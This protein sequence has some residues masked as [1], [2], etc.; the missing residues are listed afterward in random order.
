MSTMDPAR[1]HRVE[2]ALE[3]AL[4]EPLDTRERVIEARCGKDPELIA[5][6]RSLLEAH[7][8][9]GDF[10]ESSA[11]TFASEHLLELSG[12]GDL[13]GT[14]VGRYRLLE[15]IGRGGMGT[16]WLAERADGQFEQRVA[17]KL[18]RRGMDSSDIVSRF[19]RERQILA[20]LEHPNI[21]RLLDGGVSEDGRPYFVME[22]VAGVPITRACTARGLPVGERLRR[23]VEVC[24]AVQYAH[25][26]LIIHGDIK[27]GN[28][29]LDE[30]GA[31]KL[32]D[33]G[34]ARLMAPEP[35]EQ[36]SEGSPGRG[37]MTPEY[38]SPEQQ[39]GRP[40]TTA[41]DV[42]QLG[43]LLYEL[44]TAQRLPRSPTGGIPGREVRG[45]LRAI[46]AK[47]VR[48]DPEQRYPSVEAL[49]DD[50]DRH[51]AARRNRVALFAAGLVAALAIGLT[52]AYLVRIRTERDR[53]QREAAKASEHSD[54]LSRIFRGWSPDAADRSSVSAA[55]LLD[56]AARRAR[57]ELAAQPELLGATL[58]MLG[59][60]ES[61]I[62]RIAVADTLLLEA[63][64]IQ[65]REGAPARDRA[66]T[67][68]RQGWVQLESGRLAEAEGTLQQAL[69]LTRDGSVPPEDVAQIRRNLG[70][71]L[72]QLQRLPDAESV[73]REALAT[74]PEDRTP[75]RTEL[76]AFLGYVL[77][78]QGRYD[79]AEQLI[80]PALI[81]QR[82]L[83]G[84][85]HVSTLTTMR[86]LAS[87]LRGPASLA[88]A[89]ALDREA[90][91]VSR[92]LFG[93]DHR[94][95]AAT[96]YSL[97][98]LLERKGNFLAAD[99]FGTSALG[100]KLRLYGERSDEAA[101]ILRTL[102]GI[103]LVLKDTV[104]AERLLLRSLA[105]F[106]AAFPR[107]HP[108]EGDVLNRLAYLLIR[109]RAG[110]ADSIYRRAIGFEQAR[111]PANPFF[112]T[113]GYEYLAWA[114]HQ[115]GDRELAERLYRRALDLYR[116]EL[117]EEHPYRVQADEGL[118]ELLRDR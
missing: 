108:D 97:A 56:D 111:A 105:S 37:P 44:V 86:F 34:V 9:A 76:A 7:R 72:W 8:A 106:Q 63:L 60:F 69:A 73:L 48:P 117:P 79:E 31:V 71:A 36:S 2:A 99:S 26:N 57:I 52:A 98:V 20:R 58:S 95:T 47:A 74:L 115:R 22:Q 93:T 21:A 92:I 82:Q 30:A 28:V 12:P 18:V 65:E 67:L 96:Y 51:L 59:D 102:G 54:V 53:A 35:G 110:D 116:R 62:G 89:E 83:F 43:M 41:S 10:L 68:A 112:V 61:G 29:L 85:R 14:L 13:P 80:R 94:E 113:D 78:Q 4:Q 101:L 5:E 24:R 104:E 15:E 16:V 38:A 25:R 11:S 91:D 77:F 87:T 19:L 55:M 1:W 88:E 32:L 3:A 46:V 84:A 90:V 64:R 40:V 75:L 17:L 109:R 81:A 23:F 107:G 103:R 33:F 118:R 45:H 66:A 114:A 70:R 27:P 100:I 50:I 39:A 42:F 49:A 6:V